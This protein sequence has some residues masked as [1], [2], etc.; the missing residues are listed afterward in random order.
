MPLH[1]GD[2]TPE[3]LRKAAQRDRQP[4]QQRHDQR[5]DQQPAQQHAAHGLPAQAVEAARAPGVA[6]GGG[7]ALIHARLR[8][9]QRV[10]GQRVQLHAL[11]RD[12]RQGNVGAARV[13]LAHAAAMLHR[14]DDPVVLVKDAHRALQR[15]L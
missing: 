12:R 6:H 7:E 4:P 5:A 9:R 8:K 10:H 1:F 11:R 13:A 14:A 15:G 2:L 3:A